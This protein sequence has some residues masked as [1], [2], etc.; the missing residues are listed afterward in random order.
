[1]FIL[2]IKTITSIRY[3]VL[4]SLNS[5]QYDIANARRAFGIVKLFH[6]I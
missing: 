2:K 3:R 1:M 5:S 6:L 4:E